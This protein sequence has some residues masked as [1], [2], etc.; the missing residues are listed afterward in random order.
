MHLTTAAKIRAPHLYHYQAFNVGYLREVIV[1]GTLFFCHPIS[2]ILGIADRGII[3][4]A[5]PILIFWN[6]TCSGMS[7]SA[8]NIDRTFR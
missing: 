2:M 6:N 7:A 3:S 1:G 8:R 5:S 4:T